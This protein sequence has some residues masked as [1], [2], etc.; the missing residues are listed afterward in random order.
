M[1]LLISN[2]YSYSTSKSATLPYYYFI[3]AALSPSLGLPTPSR[4]RSISSLP[5][6]RSL[7]R[8]YPYLPPSSSLS[9]FFLSP[10]LYFSQFF[11]YSLFTPVSSF[12]LS[13]VPLLLL[14][15]CRRRHRIA[16]VCHTLLSFSLALRLKLPSLFSQGR[17]QKSVSLDNKIL[18][19]NAF[20]KCVVAINV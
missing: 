3:Q 16:A 8:P 13:L 2:P 15:R 6:L 9:L 18:R 1:P 7:M 19:C 14:Q 5:L 17:A 12:F 11:S 20:P 10:L 4:S